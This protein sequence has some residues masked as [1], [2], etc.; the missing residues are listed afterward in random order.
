MGILNLSTGIRDLV[1]SSIF[2][3]PSVTGNLD[4]FSCQAMVGRL[5]STTFGGM[6]LGCYAGK[7][8]LILVRL[9]FMSLI[10]STLAGFVRPSYLV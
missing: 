7:R 8:P 9:S 6:S 3:R 2:L 4:I 5:Y 1:S 10:S